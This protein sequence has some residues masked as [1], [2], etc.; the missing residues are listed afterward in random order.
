MRRNAS[1]FDIP[2]E[3]ISTAHQIIHSNLAVRHI[4]AYEDILHSFLFLDVATFFAFRCEREPVIGSQFYA[5]IHTF[6][7][8]DALQC[9]HCSPIRIPDSLAAS[10]IHQ[11]DDSATAKDRVAA[12][13]SC[14]E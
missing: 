12:T 5:R 10:A 14:D 3:R 1:E 2:I 11:Y 8:L 7:E 13:A 9:D 4:D 6:L